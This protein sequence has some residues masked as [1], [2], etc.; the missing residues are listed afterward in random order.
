MLIVFSVLFVF[1]TNFEKKKCDA[2][3][4]RLLWLLSAKV[5]KTNPMQFK[6]KDM[7]FFSKREFNNVT[8]L[9]WLIVP[10]LYLFII[11]NYLLQGIFNSI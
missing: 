6:S 9:R 3:L 10:V 4:L 5:D 7:F 8:F 2:T 1:S 11:V